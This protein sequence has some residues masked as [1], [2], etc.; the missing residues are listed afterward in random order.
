M[1]TKIYL[2]SI[3]VLAAVGA[4]AGCGG[5]G[6]HSSASSS[7]D[8]P[9]AYDA[10]KALVL[11]TAQTTRVGGVDVRD[12]SF[13]GA[14]GETIPAYLIVPP[15]K[16]PYPAVIYAHG[17]SGSRRD[18]LPS[19]VGVAERGAVAI[20]L[21]MN[22]SSARGG[23]NPLPEG[24]DG[25]KTATKNEIESV[26]E[27]R[28]TVDLLR[29]LPYVDEN[30]LGFVGWSAGARTGAVLAGV[31]HRI[32]AY[33]LLSGGAAPVSFYLEQ[34]PKNI[35]GELKGELIQTD[36]LRYISHAAPSALFFQ[37]GRH[38]DTVPR[39][40]LVRLAG[41]GSEPKELRFYNAGHVP[42][43][44]AW[45]DSAKWLSQRLG[46]HGKA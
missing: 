5:G 46:L 37:D 17:S 27:I 35:R 39:G 36:P 2:R 20:A 14:A 30:K 11:K 25:V 40:A 4:L 29:S 7:L 38:D 6:S 16:G 41:A 26:V 45:T 22:Y 3:T 34:A 10:S 33:D 32:K 23:A 1:P 13:K 18:L 44:A 19:A 8:A 42:A 43:S 28:R 9:F 15:G 31:E 21:D 12:V 24:L